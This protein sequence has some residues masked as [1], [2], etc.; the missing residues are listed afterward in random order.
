[1]CTPTDIKLGD[2][3]Y[4]CILLSVA[5]SVLSNFPVLN[6]WSVHT[7]CIG[8]TKKTFQNINGIKIAYVFK[9]YIL[10]KYM[11]TNH[12]YLLSCD[13]FNYD[14]KQKHDTTFSFFSSFFWD[15]SP[16]FNRIK[17]P[18]WSDDAFTCPHDSHQFCCTIQGPTFLFLL[19]KAISILTPYPM[20]SHFKL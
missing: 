19:P 6:F 17:F 5:T 1:M 2:A 9:H 15:F 3:N 7:I 12:N 16:W 11:P 13:I 10:L 8:Q 18:P 20:L 14:F 4:S